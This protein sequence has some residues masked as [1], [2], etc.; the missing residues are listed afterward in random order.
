[1]ATN[2]YY[3]NTFT[4][5]AGQTARAEAVDAQY[6]GIQ[7]GFDGV[8]AALATCI[9]GQPG[10]T[11]N[12]LPVAAQRAGKTLLFD[13]NGQPIVQFSTLEWRSMWQPS[14]AYNVGDLVQSGVHQSIWYCTTPHTSGATFN[15][16]YWN[17]FIDLT[18]VAWANYYILSSAGTYNLAIA[19]SVGVDTTSGAVTLNL[20]T[21]MAVGAS[22]V[23]VTQIGGSLTGS[24]TLTISSGPNFIMGNSDNT[25]S[26]DVVNASM[27]FYWMGYPY[28]WRLRTMG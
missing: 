28:G 15:P 7:S 26:V 1:M 21:G 12:A 27:S 23:N 4:G 24:Q 13:A 5:A 11:L 3:Q 20:P 2:P 10:E 9:S 25:L 22:P 16:A 6:G 18:G 8:T 14:T 17:T 19:D